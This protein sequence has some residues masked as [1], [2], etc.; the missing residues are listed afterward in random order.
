MQLGL[1]IQEVQRD[2]L[3]WDY[4]SIIR[5][6]PGKGLKT[7]GM[8]RVPT[9][10]QGLQDYCRVFRVLLLEELKAHLLQVFFLFF[11]SSFFFSFAHIFTPCPFF[12]SLSLRQAMHIC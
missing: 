1:T 9:Q 12:M 10:F 2:L 8:K 7:L 4:H 3:V 5:A 11:C 6:S